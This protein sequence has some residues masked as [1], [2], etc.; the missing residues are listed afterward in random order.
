MGQNVYIYT[1][2]R[3][4]KVSFIGKVNY[5][6]GGLIMLKPKKSCNLNYINSYINSDKFK[7]NFIYSGRFKIGHKQISNSYI[8]CEYL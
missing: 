6:G 2:T 7:N 5:F 3:K 8:P 4:T 1:I